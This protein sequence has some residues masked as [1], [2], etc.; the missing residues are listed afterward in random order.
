MSKPE[1]AYFV[2]CPTR[3]IPHKKYESVCEAREV[4]RMLCQMPENHHAEIYVVRAVE[5]VQYR[6]DPFVCKNYSKNE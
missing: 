5:S 2:F 3:E 4:A 6:T 1:S